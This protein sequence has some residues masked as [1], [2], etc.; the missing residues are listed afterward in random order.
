MVLNIVNYSTQHGFTLADLGMVQRLERKPLDR[1][2][3]WTKLTP[4]TSGRNELRVQFSAEHH[5]V[6]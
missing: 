2:M 1:K 5:L 4:S 6:M 3:S